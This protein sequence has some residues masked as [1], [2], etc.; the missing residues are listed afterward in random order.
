[1]SY[2]PK[3]AGQRCA[4]ALAAQP[5]GLQRGRG[6]WPLQM[7]QKSSAAGLKTPEKAGIPRT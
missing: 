6:I 1:M 7:P 4:V 5:A 2:A 3:C